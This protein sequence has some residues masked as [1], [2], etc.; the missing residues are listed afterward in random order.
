[1]VM[2]IREV[3]VVN[4]CQCKQCGDIIQSWHRYDFVSCKCG[5][6][7]TDGGTSYIRRS[8]KDFHDIID[9]SETYTQEYLSEF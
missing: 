8:A 5:A 9:L 3:V 4:R 6:I 1:M 7:S 2:R